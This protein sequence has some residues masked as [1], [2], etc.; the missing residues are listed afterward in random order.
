MAAKYDLLKS[1]NDKFYFNLKAANGEPILTSQMYTT[2]DA[3][4]NGIESV[5]NHSPSDENYER[6][7]AKDNSPYFVLKAANN[8][9]IGTSEMYSSTSARDNGIESV[10]T[11]GPAAE[12]DDQTA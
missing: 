12:T 2:K 4:V 7:T 9:V 6:L 8:Q 5:K 1:S 11:N 10:K 3:A